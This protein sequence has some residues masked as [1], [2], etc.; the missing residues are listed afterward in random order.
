[1]TSRTV[2]LATLAILGIAGLSRSVP[3][4]ATEPGAE[5]QAVEAG[6]KPSDGAAPVRAS[7]RG[8]PYVNLRDGRQL[9]GPGA[10]G[11]VPRAMTAADFD[12][13]GTP[14]LAAAYGTGAQGF[15]MVYRGNVDAIHPQ[16]DD[17]RLRRAG[18]QLVDA[19]LI[20][21]VDAML[22]LVPDFVGAGDFNRDGHADI[23]AAA[24]GGSTLAWLPG[25]GDGRFGAARIVE[26]PGAVSNLLAEKLDR[27]DGSTD[28]V[29]ALAGPS[30][31]A[32]LIVAALGAASEDADVLAGAEVIALPAPATSLAA[33]RLDD[34]G[35]V[36]L[37]VSAGEE[38]LI[39]S[40]LDRTS[41]EGE[42]TSLRAAGISRR[43][44]PFRP[45][46]I[47][48]GDFVEDGTGRVDLGLLSQDG[49]LRVL[50]G[51]DLFGEAA[52]EV[53]RL[54][55]GAAAA[56]DGRAPLL[57]AARISSIPGE[58]AVVVD[59]SRR[60]VH[61]VPSRGARD[62]SSSATGAAAGAPV[63]LDV[64]G[65]PVAVLP[66]RLNGDALADLVVLA[67]G[68]DAPVVVMSEPVHTFTVDD[69]GDAPD[70]SATDMVCR[71]GPVDVHGICQGKCTLR[72][73]I[74]EANLQG[75]M[76]AIQFALG[77]GT[78]TITR[79]PGADWKLTEA[80]VVDGNTG[81]ATRVELDG[82]GAANVLAVSGGNSAI[83]NL[84]INRGGYGIF[85]QTSGG[86]LIEGN[87][88]GLDA[89]GTAPAGNSGYG[90]ELVTPSNTVGGT[91]PAAR[92][93][94]SANGLD[95]IYV[96]GV[97]STTI[98][99][100]YIGTDATGNAALG[101]AGNGITLVNTANTRVGGAVAGAGNV[102]SGNTGAGALQ[103]GLVANITS[104]SVIQ[105]NFIGTN[106][107]GTA[108]LGNA[109]VGLN[110][111][112]G[113]AHTIGGTTVTA[114]NVISG[115]GS[116]GLTL[117][118]GGV[119]MLALIQGNRIGTDLAG[120]ADVGNGGHGILIQGAHDNTIGGTTTGAGNVVSG[121]GLDGVRIEFAGTKPADNKVLG[122]LIGTSASGTA[123][124]GNSGDGIELANATNT[125]IGGTTAA[126]RNVISANGGRGL[127]LNSGTSLVQ[128]NIIG[129]DVSGTSAVLGNA[130]HGILIESFQTGN[131]IGGTTNAAGNTI[132]FN[133]ATGVAVGASSAT[134]H[135]IRRNAIFGNAGLGIDLGLDGVTPND[136]CD[137]D[138]GANMRQNFPVLTSVSGNITIQGTLNGAAATTFT[139]EFFASPSADASAHGEGQ[140]FLGSSTVTTNASCTA[141]FAASLSKTV[142][143]GQFVTATATDPAGNTSEFSPAVVVPGTVT[144]TA[145]NT[146]VNW[147]I[148]STQTIKWSQN[149]GTGTYVRVEVSRDGG[150]SW[151]VIGASVKNAATAG[152]FKWVVTGPATAQAR[153]RVTSTADPA[154]SDVSNVNFTIASP[155]LTVTK[156][157]G[158]ADVWTV[159][160]KPTITWD[161]NLGSLEKV[162]ID[163]S[164][165]G[166]VTYPI[167]VLSGT[168][169]DGKQA[170]VVQSGWTSPS[171]RVRI[172]WIKNPAV[173]DASDANF[174][175]Q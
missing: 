102:I 4:S 174:K 132:A 41:A 51:E 161:S 30:A 42:R 98:L 104:G 82:T 1:M 59:R 83:R 156:P 19:P 34:D 128:G 45:V 69:A 147:A 96:S 11:A 6:T 37:A 152:T 68:A 95:G 90:I 163:L 100:N 5:R 22:P 119:S 71:T 110:V 124:L 75:G 77:S 137:A 60:H 26:L 28:I 70:C 49:I 97:S 135:Q 105:G 123:A 84:V 62:M 140:V 63:T 85:V 94:I 92:N 43:A 7:G 64:I 149:L 91:T 138:G 113:S 117:N 125:T 38:L 39:I 103:G 172:T 114:R 20:S 27:P 144:V 72:A 12:E 88:I 169:S 170:V 3:A 21:P 120:Q 148:G 56:L 160:T 86:N 36:D 118:G 46:A 134:S 73:A 109:S 143:A 133:G 16:T 54:P 121:N 35:L 171:A 175:V 2:C 167:V 23:V 112:T 55:D 166:G 168:P 57:F 130:G 139:I 80:A 155:F 76:D 18:G 173:A 129:S 31:S 8:W 53:W 89:G 25:Y 17:A 108:P 32:I 61:V 40:G 131:T 79:A 9:P 66:M 151:S 142:A 115:N 24:Q 136:S 162:R 150:A 93:V 158:S 122:N 106:A 65:E 146:A 107:S 74:S 29:I 116:H 127:Y 99:G 14:D 47:S 165:D 67:E 159:G 13:D 141:T 111:R 87:L 78:P 52:T 153:I 33:G 44:L 126:A 50:S 101:N 81:G 164:T 48:I 10:G 154:V 58:N 145:P 157:N 15:V